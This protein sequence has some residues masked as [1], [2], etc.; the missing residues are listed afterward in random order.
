MQVV[1]QRSSLADTLE[2]CRLFLLT[3]K[4]TTGSTVAAECNLDGRSSIET[5]ECTI[6]NREPLK[7]YRTG[8]NYRSR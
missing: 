5:Y 7:R 4:L 8:D 3:P 6:Q 2:P 1:T